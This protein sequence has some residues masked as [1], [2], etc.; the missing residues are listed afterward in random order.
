LDFTAI[1][2][3]RQECEAPGLKNPIMSSE[4]IPLSIIRKCG[5][6]GCRK[7]RYNPVRF[8]DNPYIPFKD[9]NRGERNLVEKSK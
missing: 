9:L 7:K 2:G 5:I 3:K 1:G 8:F 4:F 6:R